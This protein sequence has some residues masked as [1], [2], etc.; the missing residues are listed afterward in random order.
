MSINSVPTVKI[1]SRGGYKFIVAVITDTDGAK[2]L[3]VRA[4]ESCSYHRD[5][6]SKLRYEVRPLGLDA[7]CIGG[8]Q[9]SINPETKNISIRGSSGD[10]GVEPDRNETVRMLQ[11][12]YP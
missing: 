6:L 8:G 5:I 10:F 4:D 1:D 9:I 3:V 2:L 7:R 11:E 12:A